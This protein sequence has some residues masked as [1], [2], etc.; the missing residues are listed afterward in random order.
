MAKIA[1]VDGCRGGWVVAIADGW[2]PVSQIKVQVRGTFREVLE[3]TKECE[4]I[5]I[6]IPIG[7]P[8]RRIIPQWPG[9]FYRWP[10][11]CDLMARDLLGPKGKSRVFLAPPRQTLNATDPRSFQQLHLETTGMKAS[12]P[13]WGILSKIREVD[14]YM[15]PGLQDRVFEFYPELVWMDLLQPITHTRIDTCAPSHRKTLVS[16]HTREGIEVRLGLLKNTGLS[17]EFQWLT[18]WKKWLTKSSPFRLISVELDDLLDALAGLKA[19]NDFLEYQM[20]RMKGKRLNN[21]EQE[22]AD[23]PNEHIGS[24]D[25]ERD[26]G[27]YF[28]G[29][30]SIPRIPHADPPKDPKGL[31]MEIWY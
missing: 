11:L 29:F 2:P 15:S 10:R 25:I 6:D 20:S 31:R 27:L 8:G 3:V 30:R 4:A 13:V 7:L 19:A 22:A 28:E 9:S 23:A 24:G 26:D 1:G 21:S 12:L 17:I 16:K 5:A 14:S 18:I